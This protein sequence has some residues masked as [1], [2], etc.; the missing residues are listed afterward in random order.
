MEPSKKR[1]KALNDV[2]RLMIRKRNK[3]HPLAHQN[4]LALWFTQ[5]TGHEINQEMISKILSKAYDHLDSLDRKKDK[6]VLQEKRSSRGDWPNL[7]AALFEWQ[8]RMENKKAT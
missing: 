4:D 6:V 2:D 5:E 3:I 1:R 7:E 8:Q